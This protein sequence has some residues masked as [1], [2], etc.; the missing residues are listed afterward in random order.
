[1]R[2]L[3]T[4]GVR[5]LLTFRPS[6]IRG[7]RECRALAA[8]H[9]PPATRKAGGSHHRSSRTS[10]IPCAAVLTLIR[11]LLGAP[12]LLATVA[13]GIITPAAWHQRRDARTTRLHVRLRH[14]RRRTLRVHRIPAATH[15]DDWPN[16]PLHAAGWARVSL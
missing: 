12:G 16:A 2:V 9:G 14:D 11:A 4:P 5:V 6:G 7:R 3:A 13:T 8:T 10:G 15:R 1:M